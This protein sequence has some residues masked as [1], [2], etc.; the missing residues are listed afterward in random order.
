[1]LPA[2]LFTVALLAG[3]LVGEARDDRRIK[4]VCKPLASAGFLAAAW[5]NGAA[6]SAYG[7]VVLA[8]LVLS[9]WGDVLLIP[10]NRKAFLAGLVAFLLGHVALGAAFLVAGVAWPWVALGVPLAVAAALFHRWLAPKVPA[11]LQRPVI[12]YMV[13][14]TVMVALA[15]G[16]YGAGA[17]WLVPAGAVLFWLSDVSVALDRFAGAGFGN[18]LWGLPAYYAAQLLFAASVGGA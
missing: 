9:F 15:A 16:A 7:Q 17:A 14:I 1:M 2:A 8:A 13:V 18:R 10:R 11:K 3:T 6:G 5:L 12:A 4:W